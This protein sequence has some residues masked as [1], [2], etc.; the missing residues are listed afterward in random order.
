MGRLT[1][2]IAVITGGNSGIGYA[3]AKQFISEGAKVII[4]GRNQQAV[5][6]A[7]KELGEHATGFVADA[8]NVKET[9]ALAEKVRN[10]YGKVDILFVNAGVFFAEPVGSLTE[11]SYNR[12]MDVNFKGAIFTTE[13]FI[14]LLA[15]GASVIHLS[16]VSAFAVGA[17]TAV[18][19]ASK[20]ALNAY[21]RTAAIEL[22]GKKIRVNSI[23]PS[24]VDTALSAKAGFPESAIAEMDVFMKQKMPFKRYAQPDEVAKLAVFL[25]SD[26][27]SFISGTEY[28]IDGAVTVN[29]PF[30]G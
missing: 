23:L 1:D 3:T 24:M 30:R 21:S 22:A 16:S 17:G 5:D 26:D 10:L 2:R 15:N 9:E 8:A 18:Y 27:A 12:I 14:P 19:A 7:V 4:T 6:T 20:A 29:E 13:K 28:V 25:A 11:D